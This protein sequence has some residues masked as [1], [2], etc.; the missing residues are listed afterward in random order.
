ME[1]AGKYECTQF[2]GK[3]DAMAQKLNPTPH[4]LVF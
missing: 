3:V 4:Q 1:I 2:F